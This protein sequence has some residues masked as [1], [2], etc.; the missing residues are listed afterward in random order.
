MSS[1]T[2]S[3]ICANLNDKAQLV[4]KFWNFGNDLSGNISKVKC[5]SQ[6]ITDDAD[7]LITTYN[8]QY[9]AS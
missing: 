2:T 7:L 8:I 1:I 4:Q 5:T 3:T 6:K 9:E